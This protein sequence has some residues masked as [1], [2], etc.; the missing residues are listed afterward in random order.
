MGAARHTP[1]LG[2]RALGSVACV[3]HPFAVCSGPRLVLPVH[4]LGLSGSLSRF[5]CLSTRGLSLTHDEKWK[6]LAVYVT[7]SALKSEAKITRSRTRGPKSFPCETLELFLK[8][9]IYTSE[10]PVRDLKS[11]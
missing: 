4:K 5:S 10:A 2:G 3:L 1:T 7:C 9:K 11:K 6:L 8:E